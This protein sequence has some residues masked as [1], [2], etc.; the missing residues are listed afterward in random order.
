MTVGPRII[1]LLFSLAW[2]IGGSAARAAGPTI[3]YIPGSTTRLE[4]LIGDTDKAR[5]QPTANQT[6][7][8]FGIRGTDL[9][10]SFE[11]DGKAIF[12]FGDTMGRRGGDV[13]GYSS[14]TNPELP[15]GLHLDFLLDNRGQYLKVEPPNVD[16]GGFNVP[17][18]GISLGGRM[19]VVVKTNHSREKPSDVSILTVYDEARKT[20]TVLRELSRLPDGRVIKMSMHAQS[21]ERTKPQE[22][23]PDGADSPC[24]LVWSAGV[25]RKSDPYLSVVPIA[26]FESGR[27]TRYFAGLDATG[28]PNWSAKESDARALFDHP[29]IGD[30]SVTWA[31]ALRQ[32]LMTYDSREPRGIIFRH[33]ANPWGP[34]SEPQ[35]IFDI[36]RD[37]GHAF[38]H[39]AGA[40]DGLEGPVIGKNKDAA[41]TSG[42]A[43][44]PYV[45]ER[46]TKVENGTLTIYYVLST[47]N[48]YVVVLMRSSF[49]V[50]EAGK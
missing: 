3:T 42:G 9:G 7:A 36:R 14:T 19:Y 5:K 28:R 6:F 17:V 32:W 39:R 10:Y 22:G 11:H 38:I 50:E 8:R 20:F 44:A 4:Q 29:T 37:D 48:P 45:V 40:S 18:S 2:A 23:L 41:A 34:W 24:V 27:G 43:Y 15:A 13:I 12:L 26:D 33:A 35:I 31:P 21:P 30:L 25:Y 49:N 46:F 47:W 16:M 1:A